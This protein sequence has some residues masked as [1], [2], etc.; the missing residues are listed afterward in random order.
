MSIIQSGNRTHDT[1]C[2]IAEGVRQVAVAAAAGNQATAAAAEIVF[3][4]ACRASAMANGI[5]EGQFSTALKELGTGG[6]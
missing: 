2:L 3:Y 6:V 1:T 4:R 5:Q